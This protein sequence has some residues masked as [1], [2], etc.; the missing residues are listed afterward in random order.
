MIVGC[1]QTLVSWLIVSWLCWW[2]VVMGGA[3]GAGGLAATG[4][5][6]TAAGLVNCITVPFTLITANHPP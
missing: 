3:A 6:C 2:V 5:A 1:T 4:A